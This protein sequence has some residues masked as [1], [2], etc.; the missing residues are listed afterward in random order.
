[1]KYQWQRGLW[2]EFCKKGCLT[3]HIMFLTLTKIVSIHVFHWLRTLDFMNKHSVF[4]FLSCWLIHN[5]WSLSVPCLNCHGLHLSAIQIY[6]VTCLIYQTSY[7][8]FLF[9]QVSEENSETVSL[10]VLGS[11]Q[12]FSPM[13]NR[14]LK[15]AIPV[16][17]LWLQ[18]QKCMYVVLNEFIKNLAARKRWF[19]FLTWI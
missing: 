1:M 7:S 19:A 2:W 18:Y 13:Q 8:D 14:K 4:R 10:I 17:Q 5:S 12:V 9:P 16:K 6:L 11:F 3:K 15:L